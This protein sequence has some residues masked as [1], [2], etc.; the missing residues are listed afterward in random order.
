MSKS[1]FKQ[2]TCSTI[3]GW[4]YGARRRHNAGPPCAATVIKHLHNVRIIA[5]CQSC[6]PR[7][8]WLLDL[9]TGPTNHRLDVID[10][11][12]AEFGF[13]LVELAADATSI[14]LHQRRRGHATDTRHA[15]FHVYSIN[16]PASFCHDHEFRNFFHQIATFG[17]TIIHAFKRR[18]RRFRHA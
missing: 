14:Q 7:Y 2:L 8:Y 3:A 17:S 5:S 1:H 12:P 11:G 18:R 16:S 15:A 13:G 9:T 6:R 10:P 4:Q